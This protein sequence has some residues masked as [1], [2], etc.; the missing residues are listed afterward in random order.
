MYSHWMFQVKINYREFMTDIY[1][2]YFMVI[3]NSSVVTKYQ[4]F[5]EKFFPMERKNVPVF[6]LGTS[7]SGEKLFGCLEIRSICVFYAIYRC[8]LY[9]SIS[10]NLITW[11][12]HCCTWF[13]TNSA[14]DQSWIFIYNNTLIWLLLFMK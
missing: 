9:V 6:I 1:I 7:I 8:K 5:T 2:Y 11:R 10:V 14:S 3:K 12:R 13:T 4:Y